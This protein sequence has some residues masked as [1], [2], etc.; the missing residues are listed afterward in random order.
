MDVALLLNNR[1]TQSDDRYTFRV[2]NGDGGKP[3]LILA[4][5]PKR[6]TV[7]SIEEWV[8]AFQVLVAIY[9]EKKLLT[10]PRPS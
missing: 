3:T 10:I 8:S 5:N 6:Q 2:V 9:S 1:F 7:Q 4:P